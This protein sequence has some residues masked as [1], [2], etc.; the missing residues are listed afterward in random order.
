MGCNSSK[1]KRPQAKAG[2]RQ[3]TAGQGKAALVIVDVQN[4]FCPGGK[5]A[6]PNWDFMEVIEKLRFDPAFKDK[7]AVTYF[8]RD[9]KPQNCYEFVSNNPGC[10]MYEPW[11]NEASGKVTVMFPDYA[12]QGTHAAEVHERCKVTDQDVI[13]NKG[14]VWDN[15]GRSAFGQDGEKTGFPE[16]L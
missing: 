15:T 4:E 6:T 9:W 3:P 12:V 1:T 2:A 14:C 13:I 5:L 8:T 11:K 10:T 7:F 16:D